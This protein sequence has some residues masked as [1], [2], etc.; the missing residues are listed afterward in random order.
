[1]VY[2]KGRVKNKNCHSLAAFI[3]QYFAR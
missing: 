2:E 3:Q 1:M